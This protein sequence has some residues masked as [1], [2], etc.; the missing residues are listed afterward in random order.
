M[1]AAL[2]GLGLLMSLTGAAQPLQS[3]AQR[4]AEPA[5]AALRSLS[6]PLTEVIATVGSLRRLRAENRE[7]RL[8]NERLR[9]A[10]AQAREDEV[11]AATLTDLLRLGS[12]FG[13][14]RLTVANVIARDPSPSRAVVLIDRGTRDGV[15]SGMPVL[16]KGG[17]LVGTVERTLERSAWVRLI[18]DPK[19]A[20]NALIQESRWS[21]V[22]VGS[23][24]HTVRME[25]LEQGAEV[26][27]GDT[28]LTSG[29]GGM[30]PAGLLIGRVAK[31]EGGPLDVFKRVQ[32][33]PAARLASL[34]TVA[35]LTGFHPTP[36]EGLGR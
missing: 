21:A 19:S 20:A 34:E 28:V 5:E 2:A 17:A 13:S 16:G 35:V 33:E 10:L 3:A 30:Y 11:R 15:Q 29:L 6:S 25:F 24:D 8:E 9:T 32:V 22:A 4:A 23:P 1:V 27:P 26:K 7:L 18:T 12:Q 31:V 14:D 36:I